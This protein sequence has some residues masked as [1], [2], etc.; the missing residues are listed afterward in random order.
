MCAQY[1]SPVT[2]IKQTC[3]SSV[4]GGISMLVTVVVGTVVVG[5]ARKDLIGVW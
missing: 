2:L 3:I 4:G 5:Y 1:V